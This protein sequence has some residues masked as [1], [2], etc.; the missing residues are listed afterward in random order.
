MGPGYAITGLV[1]GT[2]LDTFQLGGSGN[3]AFNL[4]LIGTQYTG[5][6]TFN[7]VGDAVWTATGTYAQSDPWTV[8]SGTLLVNGDLSNAS[9]IT[10]NGGTLGGTGTVG[11][12]QINAGGT[13]APGAQGSPSAGNS[14]LT[15]RGNLAFQS[16]ALYLVQV[17]PALA[18]N[19]NVSGTASLAGTVEAVFS[20]GGYVVRS[21]DILHAA[22]G[23]G[24][25][26]FS[27]LA[28]ST[29]PN[30][31]DSLSYTAT[32]VYLNLI[33][34]LGSSITPLPPLNG[35]QQSVVNALNAYF[36]RGGALP[37]NF[38]AIFAL[39]GGAL[40]NALTQ[41]DGEAATGAERG[42]FELMTDFMGLMLDPFASGRGDAGG[43]PSGIAS[44]FAPEA[45]D[46]IALPFDIT[47][48]L[49][50]RKPNFDQRWTAWGSAYGGSNT[51][52]GDPTVG[53]TDVTASVYGFA[54][55]MD[56]HFT[57]DTLF[58]FALGGGGTN[59]GLSQNLG[60]GRS[61]AFQAGVYGITK[62]GPAYLATA[63]AFSNYLMS[64]NRIALGD[65][66]DAK[67]NA[68]SMARAWKPATASRCC[69][70]S[71]SRPMRRLRRRLFT[72]QAIARP[73]SPAA[74]S[75]FP[76]TP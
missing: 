54:A 73:I 71:A 16:G 48:E 11:N 30:F 1:K 75:G 2:D 37:P 9:Q 62:Q 46:D 61:D 10:V 34:T 19:A 12:S 74:A 24:G 21:Y 70:A 23:L 7:V 60:S 57:P 6:A 13:L 8:Q 50:A 59:W 53:S 66:L 3:A 45:D 20:P 33:A 35:N 49:G 42:A 44:G 39:T 40:A 68:Q 47:P 32:D 38:V 28:G 4:S 15:I 69:R 29:P 22:S 25:T 64:T 36:D 67:F 14:T 63:L 5:F 17:N 55:G 72:R 27:G 52:K 65:Q 43:A 26:T 18:T 56:Y 31:I 76:T 51:A 41:L 58:G